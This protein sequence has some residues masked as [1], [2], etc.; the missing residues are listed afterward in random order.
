LGAGIGDL[1]GHKIK[2]PLE[3]YQSILGCGAAAAIS[4]IFNSPLGGIFFVIEV[5]FKNIEIR[6]I[7][8]IIFSAISADIFVRLIIGNKS[9][10]SI[11]DFYFNDFREYFF[12][13]LLGILCGIIGYIFIKLLY[14]ISNLFDSFRSIP[15]WVK[16]LIGGLNVGI[17]GFFIP[18]ILGTGISVIDKFLD[19]EFLLSTVIIIC[20]FKLIATS[21]TLA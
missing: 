13:I 19:N 12:Y 20:V 6:R 17:I 1:I 21:I 9:L 7:S 10:F 15:I 11:P 14:S 2:V 18:Q 8:M 4:A 5:I 3:V 16:P